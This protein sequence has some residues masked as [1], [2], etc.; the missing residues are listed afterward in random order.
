[1]SDVIKPTF[2]VQQKD[3]VLPG[4]LI[5]EGRVDINSIYIFKEGGRY[6]SSIVGFVEIKDEKVFLIPVEHA[7]LPKPNDLVIGL[8]TDVG[9]TYWTVDINS[10]YEGQLPVSETL[11]R[12]TQATI[13]TLRKF[14][15]IGDHVLLKV[16][17]FDRLR[18]PVLSM[19]G[20]GLGKITS[21]KVIEI[22]SRISNMLLYRKRSIVETI[23]RET[24]TN[25][26]IGNN[27]RIWISGKD[28]IMEDLAVLALKKVESTDL[29]ISTL[30]LI[31]FIRQ[32]KEK[33]GGVSG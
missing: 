31:D 11:L 18:D 15:S 20:K 1:M 24:E 22:S 16:I 5:A 26:F 27:A 13:D 2:Y 3:I 9:P 7:Y 30:D 25:I 12:Q 33:R 4:D 21:G 14:L 8:I 19:R 28:S 32:E 29:N 23:A 6:Y 10:P 17:S